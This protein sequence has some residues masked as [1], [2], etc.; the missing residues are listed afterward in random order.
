MV[1][2]AIDPRDI[3]NDVADQAHRPQVGD[4][5][6][7]LQNPPGPSA[8]LPP[9]QSA[10]EL[11]AVHR[12]WAQAHAADDPGSGQEAAGRHGIDAVKTKVRNRISAA[13]ASVLPEQEVDRLL[14]GDLIRAVDTLARRVDEIGGR[15]AALEQLVE[16]VVVVASGELT[17]L[18][19][20]VKPAGDPTHGPADG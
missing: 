1:P 11:A 14:I 5:P 3:V 6:A 8:P 9:V 15:V 13:A 4:P 16:E 17:R 19:A 18:R 7:L 20:A 2:V 10:E 12:D